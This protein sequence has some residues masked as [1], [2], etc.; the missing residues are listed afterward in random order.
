MTK[1][2]TYFSGN[3]KKLSYT[4][5]HVPAHTSGGNLLPHQRPGQ[6]PQPQVILLSTLP[7]LTQHNS[8]SPPPHYHFHVHTSGRS[9]PPHQKSGK[10]PDPQQP[11]QHP[12]P[13]RTGQLHENQTEASYPR[14]SQSS[15]LNLRGPQAISEAMH[16]QNCSPKLGQQ[17]LL[18]QRP[19]GSPE[20]QPP[21]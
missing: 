1:T 18:D 7:V 12:K 10:N 16:S 8:N 14:S 5:Y 9:L 3:K 15:I 20:V 6:H 21:T 2:C 17:L 4:C 11:D 19:S 13:Q